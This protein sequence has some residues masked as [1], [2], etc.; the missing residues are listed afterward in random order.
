M[1]PRVKICGITRMQDAQDAVRCGADALGFVFYEPSPR[2]IQIQTAYDIITHLPPLITA[3]GLFVNPEPETV[4]RILAQVPLDLLQFH[5]EETPEQCERFAR[6]YIKAIRMR[7]DTDLYE[8]QRQ[9]NSAQGLLLD[10]YHPALAGGSGEV[11]DWSR[12][13]NDLSKPILLAGGLNADNVSEAIRRVRPYAVDVSSGVEQ[14]KGV[15][16]KSKIEAFMR[17]VVDV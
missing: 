1:R 6:K 2:A 14:H 8:V 17:G 7:D 13:P 16:D 4:E 15:K 5:G 3:V 12:I 9:Y 11:F 10:T